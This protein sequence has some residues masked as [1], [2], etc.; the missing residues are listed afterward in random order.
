[1]TIAGPPTQRFY[2]LDALRAVAMMLG[3]VLHATLFVLPEP[4]ILWPM[5]DPAAIGKPFY[6]IVIDVIHGF[7]MPVFFMLSGYFSAL[8]W[9]RR[10]LRSLALQ[11]LK[12]VGLPFIVACF[13]ILPLSV[14][15]MSWMSGGVEPYNFPLWVLPLIWLFG[16]LGHLWFLWYL[17][18][19][20]ACF[21]VAARLG[22]Q[23]RHPVAWWLAIPLTAAV[24]LVMVEPVFG[25]DTSIGLIPAPAVFVYYAC[26]FVFGAYLYQGQVTVSRWWAVALLPAAAAF[27][28]GYR[29]LSQHQVL[30]DG[31]ESETTFLYEHL[32]TRIAV[33][34]EV[35]FAWLMCFGLMGLFVLVASRASFTWRYLSDASYWMYLSHLPLV[36][37]GQWLAIGWPVN[38]HVKFLVV[39]VGVTGIVL[40]TYQFGVRYTF[41]GNALNGPRIRRR[42][43]RV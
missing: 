42:E 4:E 21:L 38:H 16:T 10:G 1:M 14:G 28:V 2:H 40:A 19:I 36:L 32:L 34:L 33:P 18:F 17:L 7:R 27:S 35:A 13:T 37:V 9:Q 6:R 23:F 41:V 8:L 11:R 22:V 3:I 31:S 30:L 12:R 15:L 29:L 5:H 43:A 26:F 20:S 39:C 25:S 24:S